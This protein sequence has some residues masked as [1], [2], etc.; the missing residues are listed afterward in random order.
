MPQARRGRGGGGVRGLA[1]VPSGP[2]WDPPML[3]LL[4]GFFVLI[5]EGSSGPEQMSLGY[6]DPGQLMIH[7]AGLTFV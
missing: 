2:G 1:Q 4:L 7:G 3:L 6:V 5:Q